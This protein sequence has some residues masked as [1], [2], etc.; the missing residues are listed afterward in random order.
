MLRQGASASLAI[1]VTVACIGGPTMV[2]A[3]VERG[4]CVLADH[5]WRKGDNSGL[6][7][8]IN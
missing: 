6:V 2:G 3:T 5:S 4:P 1:R 7:R 8:I